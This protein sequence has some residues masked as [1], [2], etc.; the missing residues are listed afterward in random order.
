MKNPLA[1]LALLLGLF[2]FAA[3]GCTTG[4]PA[5]HMDFSR[6]INQIRP[7]TPESVVR[8]RLGAPEKSEKGT[9]PAMPTAVGSEAVLYTYGVRAGTP[10]KHW[11]YQ[12]SDTHYH[13]YLVPTISGRDDYEVLT[14]R[15]NSAKA[16]P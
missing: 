1:P 15:A 4:G 14:V 13:V 6:E 16:A 3:P 7:G 10:Y 11:F 9:V 5:G 8:D 12:R 2:T